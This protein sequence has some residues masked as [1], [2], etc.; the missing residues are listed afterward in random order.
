M[1][2]AKEQIEQI[3]NKIKVSKKVDGIRP[4]KYILLLAIIDLLDNYNVLNNRFCF[5][6]I[7]AYYRKR[8]E[9][10]FPGID[11]SRRT[12]DHPFFYLQSEGFWSLKVKPGKEQAYDIYKNEKKRLTKK[13]LIE[14]VDYGYFDDWLFNLLKNPDNRKLMES[15]IVEILS[16][17]KVSVEKEHNYEQNEHNMEDDI[18]VRE[19]TSLFDHE[20]YAINQISKKLGKQKLFQLISN[21]Y[22][23]DNQTNNYYEY[24]L[25]YVSK[26]CIYCVELKHWSGQINI[27][28]YSW[29]INNSQYRDSPHKSN[30]F[31]SR[32]LKGIYQ[33]R[34]RTYPVLWVESVV[35]LTNPE[36]EVEGANTP[37][38]VIQKRTQNPTFESID[39]FVSFIHKVE[40]SQEKLLDE[41]KVKSIV[42]YIKSLNQPAPRTEYN[43]PGYETV[44][45]LTQKPNQIELLARSVNSKNKGLYRFRVFRPPHQVDSIEKQ[46][47]LKKA[48]NTFNAVEQFGDHP[49]IHKVWVFNNYEGDVIEGSEWSEQGT[50]YDYLQE[51]RGNIAPETAL[52][53]CRGIALA[54]VKAHE[55]GVIHRAVKPQN[56]LLV[57]D[58][59]RLINFDISYQLEDEHLTVITEDSEIKDDGYVAPELLLNQDIDEGTD[60]FSLGVIAYE[61]FTGEKPFK[62]SR[63]FAAQ[64]GALNEQM[65]NKLQDIEAPVEA[66]DVTAKMLNANQSQ[67]LKDSQQIVSA[68]SKDTHERESGTEPAI[69]NYYLNPGD[70]YDVYEIVDFIG[71]GAEA[72]VYKARTARGKTVVIKLFN[73]EVP[74]ERIFNEAEIVSAIQ[75]SG[76]VHSNN[77]IGYWQEER[78]FLEMEYID[79]VTMREKIEQGERPSIEEFNQVASYLMDGLAAFHEHI[80]ENGDPEPFLHSDVK[81]ENIIITQDNR[82]VLIDCGI[83]GRPRV[84]RFKGSTGYVP[85][86]CIKGAD[87]HFSISGDIFALGVTLW[88]WIF[89]ERPYA[90]PTIDDVPNIPISNDQNI[91][92]HVQQWLKKA[93]ATKAEDRFASIEEMEQFFKNKQKSE[94]DINE[95][96]QPDAGEGEAVSEDAPDP[97]VGSSMPKQHNFFVNYLNSMS[98]VSAGNTNATAE[99]QIDNAQF[100]KIFVENPWAEYVHDQLINKGRNVILSGNAGDGKTTI[101]AEVYKKITG[102]FKPLEVKEYIPASGVHIIKDMSELE[103]DELT[104]EVF[105]ATQNNSDKY[106]LVSN[107]GTLLKAF[108]NNDFD[109][110]DGDVESELLNALSAREPKLV[111]KDDQFLIINIGQMDSINTATDVFRRMVEPNNW[112]GCAG[113]SIQHI[114]PIFSNVQLIQDRLSVIIQ[115]IRLLYRCLFEYGTRLTMRQ[116]TGHLAYAIT[117]GYYCGDLHNYAASAV[118]ELQVTTYFFNLLFGLNNNEEV[119][120]AAIQLYPVNQIDKAGFGLLLDPSFE[121]KAWLKEGYSLPVSGKSKQVLDGIMEY[122]TEKKE[123]ARKQA[124]RLSYFV[125]ELDNEEGKRYIS[126]FLRSP[127]LLDYLDIVSSQNKLSGKQQ[128]HYRR[129]V[130]QVLQEYLTGVKLPENRSEDRL[131]ITLNR[132]NTNPGTQMVLADF[133]AESFKIIIADVYVID[134]EYRRELRLVYE[135]NSDI[136]LELKLPFLDYVYRRYK[137]EIAE[138]VSAF[139][140]NRLEKFKVK[141]MEQYKESSSSDDQ[142]LRLLLIGKDRKLEV[143]KLS[144]NH[145]QLEVFK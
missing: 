107:T 84:D 122:Y 131:Y 137:G 139:Y 108:N 120:P 144:V 65:Q 41:T 79:G 126:T 1:S 113:C 88:E 9:E 81:P 93:V 143:M 140:A 49:H 13:R 116:M 22:L 3:I 86:D 72:Q 75:S 5:Q 42:D 54:L 28:P 76:V 112:T 106:L 124:R 12:L 102:S 77:K 91:S 51:N 29:L 15:I 16:D 52:K 7:E 30:I 94:S 50:L 136:F 25:I 44:E 118:K 14:T 61:L 92:S 132:R 78:Y 64:G 133:P 135:N 45:Y 38:S 115:R 99:T 11:E 117:G 58:I 26:G 46:R 37:N 110:K 97:G 43:I 55:A 73:K 32:I 105:A 4:H 128:T 56:V 123:I 8:F 74:R 98:N 114:C 10:L 127:Q 34:F 100:D 18:L 19:R 62:S 24:D 130:L 63:S 109:S 71:E 27:R 141:L 80:D 33:H 129:L 95:E 101:A 83:A 145:N 40:G 142:I 138:Q 53:I 17:A 125:G 39:D 35:V 36:A 85:P 57:N 134:G 119:L 60:Y 103:S 87:M 67:R 96:E 20:N 104:G 23:F 21:A 111:L 89:G 6:D 121:K 48:Y 2:F 31:K 90:N 47:F 82:A 69:P 66:I 59:P 68:F 70:M